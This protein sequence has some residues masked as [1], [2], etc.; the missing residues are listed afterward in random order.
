MKYPERES[1]TVELKE[2]PTELHKLIKTC[3]AFANDVG[4]EIVIGVEDQTREIKGLDVKTIEALYEKIPSAVFDSITPTVIPEV[5]VKNFGVASVLI[6]RI[7]PGFKKPYFIKV[8]GIP[9]GIYIRVGPHTR[10]ATESYIEE[11]IASSKGQA[12]DSEGIHIDPEFLYK[13]E[14]VHKLL[15]KNVTAAQLA[16]EGL[17]Q[18]DFQNNRKVTR[19]AVIAFHTHPEEFVPE[20]QIIC[21][22][23]KGSSGREIVQ[24]FELTG[25]M[26]T[27]AHQA[28]VQTISFIEKN[29]R[30][31]KT[32]LSAET[33][34]PEVALREAIVNALVHRKY[35]LAG[36][37]KIAVYDNRV[38]IFSPGC[39]PSTISPQ[40]IGDGST[41]L[42]NPLLAKFA[43]KLKLIEKLGTGIL[44]MIS[45]CKEAG[46]KPPEFSENGDFVKVVFWF[47]KLH[48]NTMSIED[49]ILNEIQKSGT[50]KVE[51][52]IRL[53]SVSRNTV[54]NHLNKLI[55]QKKIIRKGQGRGVIYILREKK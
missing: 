14:L 39:F 41:F 27:L 38:E 22:L 18:K 35:S 33:P 51:T 16:R 5:F 21:T 30:L 52:L 40:N 17:L 25:S 54:T 7:N 23:F 44:T 12:Y 6:I 47:E 31:Q 29:Y 9:K 2:R 8:E 34:V 45:S 50:I 28:L 42:R 49:L 20:A 37:V 11:L 36:S 24:S 15:G 43:R 53:T 26:S 4:G 1:K 19:A 10:V 3:V 32:Q 13:S 46:I 55:Q 48:S